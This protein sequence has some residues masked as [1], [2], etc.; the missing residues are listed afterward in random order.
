MKKFGEITKRGILDVI[1]D[2]CGQSCKL[3]NANNLAYATLSAKWPYGSPKDTLHHQLDLCEKC[4]DWLRSLLNGNGVV[5][6]EADYDLGS[7]HS[8][9]E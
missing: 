7:G 6:S 8:D 3:Q 4:F 9:L 5:I 1:C 2:R